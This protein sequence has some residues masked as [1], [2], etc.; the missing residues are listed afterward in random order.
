MRI[1]D[2][3]ALPSCQS[4]PLLPD[5]AG[6]AELDHG[7]HRDLSTSR[8]TV[9][10][11]SEDCYALKRRKIA[12]AFWPPKPNPLIMAVSTRALRATSGT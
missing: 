5:Q 9:G 8:A 6:R 1:E 10:R 11:D 3:M 7:L 4:E 12:T 2:L